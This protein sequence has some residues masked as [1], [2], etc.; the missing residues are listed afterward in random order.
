MKVS[1]I[2]RISY[3]T[4]NQ[5]SHTSEMRLAHGSLCLVESESGSISKKQKNKMKLMGKGAN[6]Q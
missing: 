1:E 6:G 3:M 5:Q 2:P 4:N